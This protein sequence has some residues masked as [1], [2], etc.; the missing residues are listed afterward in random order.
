MAGGRLR[1]AAFLVVVL[2]AT[3][4]GGV[5]QAGATSANLVVSQIYGGGGNAGSTLTHDFVELFNRGSGA[6]PLGGLVGP[7]H[8]RHRDG[9]LRQRDEPDHRAA[10]CHRSQPATTS[11]CR[12]RATSRPTRSRTSPRTSR[13]ATPIAMSATLGK[14]GTRLR[15]GAARL[16]RRHHHVHSDR[17]RA[18]RRPRRLRRRQL[19]RGCGP[20]ADPVEHDR[21]VPRRLAGCTDTDNNGTDFTAATAAPRNTS[22]IRE[23]LQLDDPDEPV[24]HRVGHSEPVVQGG[25]MTLTVAVTPGTNPASSGLSV[26]VRPHVDR[27]QRDAAAVRRRHERRPDRRAT[28]RSP[29][30]TAVA[31]ATGQGVEACP[32][33]IGDAQGR[34]G[35]GTISGR[36]RGGRRDDRDPRH[37]GRAH[38]SPLGR[39]D[40]STTCAGS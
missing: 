22:T 40:S 39:A 9:Q 5:Q 12:R 38:R 15:H 16:Q 31:S 25:A 1:F 3:V 14:G 27:R 11:S 23:R 10:G 32:F 29:Y 18:H 19:L 24:R 20:D 37:P 34:S 2:V 28:A 35:S 21:R 36:D 26:G 30:A 33:T 7:V 4:A 17:A 8:E 13:D 6:V